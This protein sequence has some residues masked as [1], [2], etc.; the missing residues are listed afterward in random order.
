MRII[1]I[2][3]KKGHGK[4][5]LAGEIRTELASRSRRAKVFSFATRLKE[6]AR[7]SFGLSNEQI[8]GT[9]GQKEEIDP[10]WGMSPRTILQLFGTEVA[11]TIDSNV[12]VKAVDR[13]IQRWLADMSTYDMGTAIAIIDDVRYKNEAEYVG[14]HG[15][16]ARVVR[17]SF[18]T[19]HGEEHTSETEQ[20]G[21]SPSII[22]MNDGTLLDLWN[23]ASWIFDPPDVPPDYERITYTC[24][25]G[26]YEVTYTMED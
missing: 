13:D 11:R 14:M 21:L 7:I 9:L 18:G 6:A 20:D 26:E 15:I 3:G 16:L 23:S 10:R 5:S 22:V 24:S 12:W 1:G 2:T 19:G 4:S 17:P 8:N 25:S